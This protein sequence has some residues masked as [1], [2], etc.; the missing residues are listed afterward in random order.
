[1]V[2]AVY[3]IYRL[4]PTGKITAGEWITAQG[5]E[6]ARQRAHELCNEITPKVEIWQGGR[7]V[8]TVD[9]GPE[10]RA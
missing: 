7:L 9:C 6:D 3:R 2:A 5:D 10:H 1:M 4:A 8:A